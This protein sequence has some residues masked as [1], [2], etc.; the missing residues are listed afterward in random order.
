MA[1]S[2]P[3]RCCDYCG[4][5]V[6]VGLF[7]HE[8][9]DPSEPAYCCFGCRFAASVA[10]SGEEGGEV[11]ALLTRLG[12]ALF[13]AMNVMMFSLA[14][15]AYDTPASQDSHRMAPLFADLFRFLTL[16][17]ALPVLFL[18]GRPLAESAVEQLQRRVW[19]TDLLLLVG[20]VAAYVFSSI[21]VYR[22]EGPL[23]FEVGC[24]ILV[25]VTLGRWLEASGRLQSSSA[26]DELERLLPEMISVRDASGSIRQVSLDEV[27]IGDEVLVHAGDR[28]PIDGLIVSGAATIDDQLLTGESW[29]SEKRPGDAVVGGA[30]N[31]DGHLTLRV[32]ARLEEGTL[33]RLVAAV[34][35]ARQRKGH[36]QKLADRLSQWFFPLIAATAVGTLLVHGFITDW[37]TGFLAAL[38]VVLIACPCALGIATPLAVWEAFGVAARRGVLLRDGEALE[39]LAGLRAIRFD[40]TGTL[41]SGVPTVKQLVIA[42]KTTRDNV[43]RN[44]AALASHS[45]HLC[46]QSIKRFAETTRGLPAVT[47]LQTH[48]GRGVQGVFEEQ[49]SRG[50]LGNVRLFRELG[51]TWGKEI[52][53]AIE[54]ARREAAPFSLVG[55]DGVVY[56]LFVFREQ[57][58]PE[59]RAALAAL[60]S[61]GL[62]VAV[63]TGDHRARGESLELELGVPVTAELLPADKA[64]MVRE[65][66]TRVGSVAMIGDGVNDAPALADADVG[67]VLG[68]GADV[69]RDA[70]DCCLVGNDLTTLPWLIELSRETVSTI[71]RNLFWAFA[72][73]GVGVAVATTGWLHPAFAA[74]LMVGSSAFVIVNSMRLSYFEGSS[75]RPHHSNI[76]TQPHAGE[77]RGSRVSMWAEGETGIPSARIGR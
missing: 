10:A 46:A 17:C 24:T 25:L 58:R 9:A 22:G 34:R 16:V 42:A 40:K 49:G 14:L 39:R 59:T 62:D 19:S 44:A 71:R 27:Q 33:S 6:P 38:S 75:P 35:E 32:T 57:L 73:N 50:V 7:G 29:P 70:A 5:P 41:T 30:L 53:S 36:F 26:L 15:W 8:Q 11:R 20:V 51:Y 37:G 56:G 18:L 2:S 72:Y 13:F 68:C 28:I 54:A 61:D 45:T 76:E 21:S 63:L 23:Y 74:V 77:M 1:T 12:L 48:H 31:L 60:T 65:T 64:E 47:S 4:L 66:R 3:C 67:V 43:V 69:S 52:E 55:W